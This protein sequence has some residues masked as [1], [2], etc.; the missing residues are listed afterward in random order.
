M[1]EVKVTQRLPGETPVSGAV[2][3]LKVRGCMEP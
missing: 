2:R 3:R 1:D